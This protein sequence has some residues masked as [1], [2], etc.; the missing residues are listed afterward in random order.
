MYGLNLEMF[1]KIYIVYG[2]PKNQ[3]IL[4]ARVRGIS[5]NEK[6]N[7]EEEEC[8]IYFTYNKIKFIRSKKKIPNNF[9][10]RILAVG[11]VDN[12]LVDL[13]EPVAINSYGMHNW[14]VFT[15]KEKCIE[16]LRRCK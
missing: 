9:G 14:P 5:I 13:K 16:Y 12:D 8:S 11:S 6:V 10:E 2:D 4:S 7:S 1:Q 15:S 3:C